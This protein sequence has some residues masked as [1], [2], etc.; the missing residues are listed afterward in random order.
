MSERAR[1]L[2]LG[3]LTAMCL[4][5]CRS[6]PAAPPTLAVSA[7]TWAVVDGRTIT[8]DDVDKAYRRMRDTSQPLS[9][10]ETLAAKLNLLND[11]IT[12]DLLLAKAQGLKIEVS[13]AEIDNAYAEAKK[14]VTEEAFQQELKRRNLTTADMRDGLRRELVTQKMIEREVGSK[15]NVTDQDVSDFFNANRAQFNIAEEG[16]HLAQIVVTPVRDA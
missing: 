3:A 7:N 15:I 13:D 2:F 4:G 1:Y 16:Y 14:N 11:L 8:S 6:K 10:E 12:Q 9:D 5:A